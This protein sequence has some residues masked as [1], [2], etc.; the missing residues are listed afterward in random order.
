MQPALELVGNRRLTGTRKPRKPQRERTLL[1]VALPDL[2]R[3]IGILPG[4]VVGVLDLA[5]DHSASA[6]HIGHAVDEDHAAQSGVAL[7]AVEGDLLGEVH[8][9]K[10]DLVFGDVA[11]LH[12]R[13]RVDVD[14]RLDSRDRAHH[15]LRAD[16]KDKARTLAQGHVVHPQKLDFHHVAHHGLEI[17][18]QHAAAA[19]VDL[20]FQGQGHRLACAGGLHVIKAPYDARDLALG[21]AGLDLDAV[22]HAHRARGNGTLKAAKLPVGAAHALHG[23]AKAAR[24]LGAAHLDV[25]QILLK[26]RAVVEAHRPRGHDNVVALGC[27]YGNDLHAMHV[28]LGQKLVDLDFDLLEGLLRIPRQIHLVDGVDKVLDAHQSA[29]ARMAL[30]L[31]EHALGRIDQ[32]NGNIGK[33]RAHGHVARVLLM[34]RAVCGD[35]AALVGCEIAVGNIDGDALLAL[36]CKAV[37]Q[38]RVVDLAIGRAHL[39]VQQQGVFLIGKQELGVVE[40]MPQKRGLAVVDRATGQKLEQVSH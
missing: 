18:H 32:D 40:Q 16:A 15:R 33:T 12:H 22:A 1:H 8:I 6:R 28:K 34:P 3:D 14:A 38:K 19:D 4:E 13:A 7:E 25:F 5:P 39:G 2:A 11:G 29:D 37:E 31:D 36:G 35:K 23:H 30:G 27:A 17:I 20:V 26:R 24:Q 21:S 9:G 10:R